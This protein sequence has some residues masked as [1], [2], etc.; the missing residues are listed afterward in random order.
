MP[1]PLAAIAAT[2]LI[3]GAKPSSRVSPNAARPRV[4]LDVDDAAVRAALEGFKP[5]VQRRI[6]RQ[7]ITAG[8]R[9]IAKQAKANA[10]KIKDTGILAKS[11]KHKVKTYKSGRVVGFVGPDLR[12]R[13]TVDRYKGQLSIK[14]TKS[15]RV[16]KSKGAIALRRRTH[17]EKAVPAFYA[18]LVEYGA[19]PHDITFRLFGQDNKA[20]AKPGSAGA[21]P[22]SLR[23]TSGRFTVK[24]PG[25]KA[26]P[27]LRPALDST[28]SQVNNE[29]GKKI[30]EGIKREAEKLA[31][32]SAGR[33]AAA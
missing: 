12:T 3:S 20:M 32:K 11:I 10:K 2:S 23:T 29:M 26:R 6:L 13:D 7:A 24:H 30:R 28:R 15:G 22:E 8:A 21:L 4:R 17:R 16:S 18:H 19:A 31:K 1:L 5:S 9:I 25:A 14:R 27:F 33:R